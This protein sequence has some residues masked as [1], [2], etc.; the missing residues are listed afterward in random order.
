MSSQITHA[1]AELAAGDD[2]GIGSPQRWLASLRARLGLARGQT[3]RD[4][5]EVALKTATKTAEDFTA[6]EREI[7]LRLLR[8]GPLRVEDVMVPR[9]DIIALDESAPLSELLHTFEE[10][11]VSRIPLFHETLDDLRGMVHIKDVFHWLMAEAA[12]RP[13]GPPPSG[14]GGRPT[15]PRAAEGG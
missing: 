13:A 3:L 8:F 1:K 12:G 7:L 9:A 11:G 15:A 2:A 14:P 4:T 10:A 6:E 5:L